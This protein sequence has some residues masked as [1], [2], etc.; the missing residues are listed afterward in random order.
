[1]S[2]SRQSIALDL[3]RDLGDTLTGWSQRWMP[4]GLVVVWLLTVIS[5]VLT[6]IW[7][8]VTFAQAIVAWGKGFWVLLE[9][10]M[11]MCLVLMT[12]YI[13]ACS[14]PI[15]RLLDALSSVPS[16]EK[17]WQAITAMCIFSMLTGL[18]NWGLSL[19]GSAMFA[20]FLI[21]RN[22]RTDYRLLVASAYLG[23]GCTWHA[24]LS[25]SAPLLVN[26]PHN[27]LI[28][29][30]LLTAPISTSET[31]FT[32]FN[33]VMVAVVIVAVTTLMSLMHPSEEKTY[34]LSP[35]LLRRVKLYEGPKKPAGPLSISQWLN[36]WPGLNV[37]VATTGL[38][39]LGLE[40][41]ARGFTQTVNLNNIN[42][43][44]LMLGILFHWHPWVFL[45]AAEESARAVW[46]IVIQ[47]PFYA[48]IFGL[49]KFTALAT[50]ISKGFLAIS[51]PS[52]FLLIVCWF[53]GLINYP[54]PSGASEFA[55][56]AP[57]IIPAAQQLGVSVPKT[58]LA[59]AWGDMITDMI[60][61]FWAIA[62]LAVARLEFREIVGWLLLV[63]FVFFVITSL[64]F[65]FLP[66]I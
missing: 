66:F 5:F 25:G 24:G 18:L 15:R 58:V 38:I 2:S 43:F 26:T 39:W 54:I 49:F 63:F 28:Q 52:T 34:K 51:S 32:Y 35:E 37:I 27:F 7:G 21:R 50:V 57:N 59:Y 61:P 9:F 20:L 40:V 36:W 12:G 56:L 53:S 65:L 48:G 33:L 10:A 16:C 3:L 30:E 42:L 64:G 41:D 8:N 17:P 6:L 13:L 46:G 22:P 47:F 29:S 60:Q 44:F 31:V 23:L 4:D 1:M 11:Q 55:V 62:L 19:I 45:K 14:P